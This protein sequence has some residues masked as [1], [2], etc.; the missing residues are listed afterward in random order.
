MGF[1]AYT[2]KKLNIFFLLGESI[3]NLTFKKDRTKLLDIPFQEKHKG[4]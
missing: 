4:Q 3:E 1:S 2:K